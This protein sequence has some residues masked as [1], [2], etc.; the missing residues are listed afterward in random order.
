ME[1][2]I[3][4]LM[5]TFL[6][7]EP[8]HLGRYQYSDRVI[9]MVALWAVLHDRP[10]NWA[11]TPMNW[12]GEF[13]PKRLPSPS[14]VSRRWRRE[15][16]DQLT[17]AIHRRVV[18]S[19]G[20]DRHAAIDAKP[21]PVG[22]ASKDPDARAGRA[23]GHLAKGHKLFAVVSAT[24]AIAQ[25]EVGAMADS[26]LTRA[27]TLLRDAPPEIDRV[28]GDGLYDGLYDSVALHRIA[29][30]HQRKFYTPIRENRVG[31]RRQR[32]RLRLLKILNTPA[33]Q[34]LLKSRNLVEQVFGLMTNF[35]CGFKGLPN[36]ARRAHRVYR[37]IWGKIMTYHMYLIHL[38]KNKLKKT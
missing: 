28:V 13:R 27:R 23:V 7:S 20:L 5:I 18:A 14:T 35:A 31:R 33:G 16:I 17:Q 25:Y 4:G 8:K 36:W 37:W 12:P 38:R 34:Q 21:L 19:V 29:D 2:Q 15:Q 11:C 22:G 32:E 10:M 9:L 3:W 26:E 24:S 6:P 30:T 1:G